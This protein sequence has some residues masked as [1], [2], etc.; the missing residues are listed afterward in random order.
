[1]N[2]KHSATPSLYKCQYH[3]CPYESKRESNCKQH[4]EK[5]H[6]WAYIRSKNNGKNGKK[7]QNAKTPPTPQITTP[8]SNIFDLS[9]PEFGEASSVFN[10]HEGYSV[11][12]SANVSVVASEDSDPHTAVETTITGMDDIFGP[13][14]P[15]LAWNEPYSGNSEG[16]SLDYTPSS[17]GLPWDV[18]S[19]TN[20]PTIPSSFETSLTPQDEDPLFSGNFDWS[21]MDTDFLSYNAQL[22]TPA[23]S[24]ATKPLDAFSRNS[25]ISLEHGPT[26]QVPSLSPGA[27]GQVMLYS[28]F[29]NGESSNDEGYDDF[30][31]EN[32]KPSNDFPLFGGSCHNTESIS[33]TGN[34]NMFQDLASIPSVWSGRGTE[35]ANQLGMQDLMQLDED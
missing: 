24:V 16:G 12:R 25:S 8:G 35:L 31:T 14:N 26:S 23:C 29:S 4:M 32:G 3:P 27:H 13:W 1:M 5:A 28:P 6:G 33:S 10:S 21:N 7:T 11:S 20:A 30:G 18:A 2:D 17:H 19:P 15:N 34:E 9:S 22:I